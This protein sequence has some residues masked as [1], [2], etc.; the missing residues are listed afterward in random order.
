[1][2]GAVEREVEHDDPIGGGDLVEVGVVEREG[3]F[4]RRDLAVVD[5]E[6][7][8]DGDDLACLVE[9]PDGSVVVL[10]RERGR[11]E[12]GCECESASREYCFHAFHLWFDCRSSATPPGRAVAPHSGSLAAVTS[13]HYNELRRPQPQRNPRAGR[14]HRVAHLRSDRLRGR[15]GL[16]PL[17]DLH[18]TNS[19]PTNAS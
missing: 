11:D 18:I 3:C 10:L 17:S 4:V 1:M 2:C 9:L 19:S 12:L 16:N 5:F 6:R 8:E 7:R 14:L 15:S 13:L